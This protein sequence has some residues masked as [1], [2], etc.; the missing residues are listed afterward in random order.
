MN[1][2][3]SSKVSTMYKDGI[4][5]ESKED[6]EK[7]SLKETRG[8]REEARFIFYYVNKLCEKGEDL[9]KVCV[10]TRDNNYNIGLSE[11]LYQ[12]GGYEGADFEFILVDQFKFL[13]DKKLK[14]Y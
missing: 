8:L 5:A 3:F 14:I 13:G 1:N 7:I 12:I 9:K 4:L 11:E 10:L 6:G 2:A